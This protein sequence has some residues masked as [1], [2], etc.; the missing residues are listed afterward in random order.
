VT[1][2]NGLRQNA[3][4]RQNG[5]PAF[6]PFAGDVGRPAAVTHPSRPSESMW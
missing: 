1:A 4:A 6:Q 3:P 5:G 2:P